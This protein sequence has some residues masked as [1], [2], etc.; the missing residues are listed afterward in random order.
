MIS[1][2]DY[3]SYKAKHSAAIRKLLHRS[4]TRPVL[5]LGSG[6]T[7]R[8]LG[9]PSWS[10]LLIS[11]ACKIGIDRTQYNFLAQ[12]ANNDPAT[13]GNLLVDPVHQWA[14][15]TGRNNF[16]A[17]YFEDGIDKSIFLKYLTAE[18]L[19]S[20][21]PLPD[22]HE[23]GEEIDL[24][25][26]TS[27]HAIIT[28]NFDSLATDLFPKFNSVIGEQIIPL[29]RDAVGEI[30]QIH[31]SVSNPSSIVLT[32]SDY[33]RFAKKRRYISSK[34]MTY[35]AEYPVFIIGYGLGDSNVNSIISDLGEAMKDKGGLIE[36]VYYIEWAP[37]VFNLPHLKEEHLIPVSDGSLPP[38]RINTI[39]TSEFEWVLRCLADTTIP[40][41]IDVKALRQLE[42][43]LIEL[44]RTD[45]PKGS[46]EFDYKRI[47]ELSDEKSDLA[48]ILGI[49]KSSNPNITH[50]YLLTQVAKKLGY[51]TWHQ[52]NSWISIANKAAGYDIK[53]TDNEFHIAIMSGSNTCTHKYSEKLVNLIKNT[54]NDTYSCTPEK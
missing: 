41:P 34:M 1:Q 8:Y 9:A 43:R 40:A 12:S 26:K 21:G 35:F 23:F 44:V 50:P 37:D 45:L 47:E 49:T 2:P 25:K 14:W 29:S 7:R 42:H 11:L 5:F 3:E 16:P 36:N 31:G 38:L 10:E 54:R 24:L 17:G 13:I 30:Y 32:K 51:K 19:K 33:D 18:H 39:V 15:G 28:T 52:A 6:I 20:F 46:V 53:S 22:D 4:A 27:P 48:L